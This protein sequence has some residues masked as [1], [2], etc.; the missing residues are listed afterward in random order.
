MAK[1]NPLIPLA[2]LGV[3]AFALLSAKKASALPPGTPSSS[4]PPAATVPSLPATTPPPP[5][6]PS[7]TVSVNGHTWKLVKRTDGDIDVFA[8]AGSWGPHAELLVCRFKQGAAASDRT[9]AGAGKDV[10]KAVLD[11]ALKD[12]G[13]KV[14]GALSPSS[15]ASPAASAAMPASLQAEMVSVM[16]ALGV[17][18]NGV[19]R[20]PVTAEEV[21][22]A[23][24]L[25]SRL[26]QMGFKDAAAV[27]RGYAQQAAKMLP[28]P[29]TPAPAIPGVPPALMAAVQKA[30]ELERDPAKLQAIRDALLRGAPPSAERDMLVG[31]IDALILQIRANQ[32]ISTAATEIDQVLAPAVVPAPVLPAGP[33]A[34]ATGQRILKLVK[35][36]MTGSDVKAWQQVLRDSGYLGVVAD[37]V[38]GPATDAATID[39]QKKRGLTGDGDVGPATRAKIGTPPTA[40]LAV[41]ATASPQPDPKPKTAL[42]VAAEATATHL[43]ALQKK[44]GV[45]GSKGK[46]DLSLVKRFQSAAGGVADGLPGVNTILALAKAGIGVLPAVMYWPKAGTK[47][48]DLPAFRKEL[49]R[50]A[51]L[52]RNAGLTTLAAQLEASAARETGAGGLK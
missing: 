25:S 44:H 49:Q 33:A 13:I 31:A 35:P 38:F 22:A 29:S 24:E 42:Q 2:A 10:P 8:P 1:L 32:A 50:F 37:G 12:L 6:A 7:Q 18:A 4:V 39:W 26:E 51:G 40:P 14:P 47:A 28:A 52:A 3:G 17:D 30:L 34:A 41:P 36:Y 27:M 15:P 16:Q 45:A 21:R 23:T 11:A 46:Q 48:K 43:L 20:G 19:V 5:N 9:L